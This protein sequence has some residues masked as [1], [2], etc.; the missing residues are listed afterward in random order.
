MDFPQT[1]NQIGV[2]L[3]RLPQQMPQRGQFSEHVFKKINASFAYSQKE[4]GVADSK[5][6]SRAQNIFEDG[7]HH[8]YYSLIIE[9]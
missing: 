6:L 8:I 2:F 4:R 7:T 1:Q 3:T 5:C 9:T